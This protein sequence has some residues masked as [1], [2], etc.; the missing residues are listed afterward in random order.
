MS[1]TYAPNVALALARVQAELGGIEKL[2]P[3]ERKRRGMGGGDGQGIGYAYR[4][5]DQICAAVQPLLGK[6]GVVIVPMGSIIEREMFDRNAKPW[7]HVRVTFDWAIYGPG[8]KDDML[9]ACTFGEGDDNSDK[10]VNKATTAAY[11]N[12]LL[13]LLCIGDP[14]EDTDTHGPAE[15]APAPRQAPL[16]AKPEQPFLDLCL[17][18]E[19]DKKSVGDVVAQVTGN[20][21]RQPKEMNSLEITRAIELVNDMSDDA[22]PDD[23]LELME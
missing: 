9:P 8:G 19:L 7:V 16:P 3:Q 21:T 4:G 23:L 14:D 15:E 5:I 13:R 12:L 20:R 11:K 1:D 2:T 10:G 18:K 17:S 22:S 6:H